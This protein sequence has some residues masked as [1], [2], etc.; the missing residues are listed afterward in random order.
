MAAV[1]LRL[2]ARGCR[3]DGAGSDAVGFSGVVLALQ[4]PRLRGLD[5]LFLSEFGGSGYGIV[6]TRGPGMAAK[7]PSTG[8][9][10]PLD[11]PMD[12]HRAQRVGRAA[13]VV[14]ADVAVERADQQPVEL[15]QPDQQVLHEV[16]TSRR[17]AFAHA[18]ERSPASSVPARADGGSARTTTSTPPGVPP[19]SR[20]ARCRNRRL[21]RLRVTALPTALE[22]TNP[23]R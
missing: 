16:H 22:T 3:G 18:E 15:E 5:A 11:S 9:P 20:A 10:A 6:P 13:G 21:T 4:C 12:A 23:T 14:P 19:S 7:Q 2:A 1:P 8:Q 17:T